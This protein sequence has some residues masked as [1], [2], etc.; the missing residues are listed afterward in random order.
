MSILKVDTINEKTTGNGVVIP[1]HVIQVKEVF[2]TTAVTLTPAGGAF[3]NLLTLNIDVSSSSNYLLVH[4]YCPNLRKIVGSGTTAW[5][6]SQVLINGSS[7]PNI[8]AGAM[9]YP[10][11]FNDHRY[12]LN[13]TGLI[14]SGITSGTNTVVFQGAAQSSGSNWVFSYQG[15][16]STMIV[17]EIAQ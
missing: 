2:T 11:T 3:T 14:T 16:K 15:H 13:S 17:M 9:G 4:V 8:H 5:W 1:G 7:S 10:E 6:G 12:I